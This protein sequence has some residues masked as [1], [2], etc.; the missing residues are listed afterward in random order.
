MNT[1]LL[2]AVIIKQ[3]IVSFCV[4]MSTIFLIV[5]RTQSSKSFAKYLVCL[6]IFFPSVFCIEVAG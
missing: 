6:I 2:L 5:A 3:K 4:K 1:I